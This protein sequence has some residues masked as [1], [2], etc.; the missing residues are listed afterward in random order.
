MPDKNN[1]ENDAEKR[2]FINEKIVRP[3][4]S[5]GQV[6]GR[7]L[8][9]CLGA[10]L[11]GILAAVTFAVSEPVVRKYFTEENQGESSSISIPTDEPESSTMAETEE[12]TTQ[13]VTEPLEEVVRSEVEKYQFS[14]EDLEAMYANLSQLAKEADKGI[15][16][17][18]SLKTEMD[19]CNNP[20]ETSGLYAGA[21][22][23]ASPEEY[24][25]L[26]VEQA[27]ESADSLEITL[28]DGTQVMG[29]IKGTDS[30]TGLAVISVAAESLDEKT[31][32]QIKILELGNSYTVSQGDMVFACG[33]PAGVIHSVSS[34]QVS[35]VAKNIPVVDGASRLFYTTVNAAVSQGTFLFNTKGQ[36]IGWATSDYPVEGD[37]MTVMYSLSDYKAMLEKMTN[38][39]QAP[40]FGITGQEVPE[41]M[42]QNG[43][44]PGVYVSQT[45]VN[46]PAYNAGIQNG[47]VIT[48]IG[49]KEIVTMKD[50]QNCLD[51]L[52]AG[53][54]VEVE[55]QRYGRENYSP[56]E[57]RV[58]I[59]AR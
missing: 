7:F 33:S 17:V 39:I 59:G 23:A 58:T 48:R 40:Y 50:F 45:Q 26:T 15:V 43:L 19:W 42:R 32:D 2:R 31:A 46:G 41:A 55:I 28:Y 3:K 57:Y 47:D 51:E 54:A 18:H 49:E 6:F 53:E 13:E 52:T 16:T 34:G 4:R 10:V 27:V 20:V 5:R 29:Q 11:F 9:L 37:A 44:P 35:Y 21:I 25:I 1:L 14:I 30:V 24:L 22:I 8:L 38:G 56:I 12:T 36:L